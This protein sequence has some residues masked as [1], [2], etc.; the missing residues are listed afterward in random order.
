MHGSLGMFVSVCVY[1][2]ICMGFSSGSNQE[3]RSLT[4]HQTKDSDGKVWL[5]CNGLES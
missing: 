5:G 3:G 4:M 2:Y 1:I